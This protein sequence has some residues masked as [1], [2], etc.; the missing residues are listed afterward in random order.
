[1][2]AHDELLAG[3]HADVVAALR[4]IRLGLRDEAVAHRLELLPLLVAE[5]LG[6]GDGRVAVGLDVGED[7]A[8][9]VVELRPLGLVERPALAVREH[10][11]VQLGRWHESRGAR[12]PSRPG[13]PGA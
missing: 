11:V 12:P 8:L 13:R 4:E 9:H 6:E 3:A 10:V 1:M 2:Q 5:Q 7:P